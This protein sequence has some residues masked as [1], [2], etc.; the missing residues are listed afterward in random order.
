MQTIQLVK[1]LRFSKHR[2]TTICYFEF[3][4]KIVARF[5]EAG[6]QVLLMGLQRGISPLYFLRKFSKLL[7]NLKPDIVT[8]QYISPGFLPIL[9]SRISVPAKVYATIHQLG[10]QYGL[11]EKVIFRLSTLLA[12][13]FFCVSNEVEKSWFGKAVIYDSTNPK[14]LLSK[15]GTVYNSIDVQAIEKLCI[16][17]NLKKIKGNIINQSVLRVGCIS[18]LRYEKGVDIL[19]QAYAQIIKSHPEILLTI[20]GDGPDMNKLK[21]LAKKL[22]IEDKVTFIGALDHEEVIKY[23][24]Q[25]DI[26]VVPS[27][28]EG[29][30]LVA[31]EAMTCGKPVIATSVGGLTEIIQENV[32]GFSFPVNDYFK[33]AEIITN[34]AEHK[35]NLPDETKVKSTV[36]KRFSFEH[37]F[38][39]ISSFYQL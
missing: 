32:N 30:G 12:S 23:I 39:N 11:K 5:E 20:I 19:L 18:R 33:L 26:V 22:E 1:A 6:S 21:D 3:D 14:T 25:M 4:S 10:S 7:R 8:V 35:I 13:R 37:F 38:N 24:T 27:R 28:F 2:V 36:F 17:E 34:I 16:A 29:F 31:I 9:A 15:H